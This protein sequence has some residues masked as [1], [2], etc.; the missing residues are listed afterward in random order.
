[1]PVDSPSAL[2]TLVEFASRC[3]PMYSR[4][5]RRMGLLSVLYNSVRSA[6]V[7]G[8]GRR[9]DVAMA[10]AYCKHH[11]Q[12]LS[13]IL[14][15]YN[16]GMLREQH[17]RAG[18]L[19]RVTLFLRPYETLGAAI[20]RMGELLSRSPVR[21]HAT[22]RP[23]RPVRGSG[24]GRPIMALF[25]LVGRR[26]NLRIIWELQQ[27]SRPLTFRELRSACGDISSS[28]L[29]QRLHELA[30]VRITGHT[31]DGYALTETGHRLVAS[32]QPVLEWS[33]AWNRE[34]ATA[35]AD[36]VPARPGPADQ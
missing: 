7:A 1:M 24:T 33:G 31:G 13:A 9:S 27:A 35:A 29:T 4:I 28:V 15:L 34:L 21:P 6:L 20:T 8:M 19:A 3:L 14:R 18:E 26:W 23:G 17:D 22:P 11:L 12:N 5:R 10:R 2:A 30:D 25:D 36:G 32:L 16:K